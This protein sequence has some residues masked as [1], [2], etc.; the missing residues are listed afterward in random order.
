MRG[1][2]WREAP[3][4]GHGQPGWFVQESGGKVSTGHIQRRSGTKRGALYS[5]HSSSQPHVALW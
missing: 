1:V 5:S 3:V 4:G 2:P